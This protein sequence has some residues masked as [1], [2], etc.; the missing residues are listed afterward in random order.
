MKF[1]KFLRKPILENI[2]RTTASVVL[3]LKATKTKWVDRVKVA[4]L[5]DIKLFFYGLILL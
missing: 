1:V 4:C 3:F 5:V 2:L